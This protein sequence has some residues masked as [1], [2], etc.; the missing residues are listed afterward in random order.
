MQVFIKAI[1]ILFLFPNM[2]FGAILVC[3]G[4]EPNSEFRREIRLSFEGVDDYLLQLE[5]VNEQ[6]GEHIYINDSLPIGVGFIEIY[7]LIDDQRELWA[8]GEFLVTHATE[9]IVAGILF[10]YSRI[11]TIRADRFENTWT[12]IFHDQTRRES[13]TG[14]CH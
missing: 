9:S 12:F 4:P 6:T 5:P 13:L 11:H 14:I 8:D 10:R 7:D 3:E 2:V 1:S